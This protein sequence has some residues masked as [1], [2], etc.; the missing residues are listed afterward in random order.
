MF[1]GRS[2][3]DFCPGTKFEFDRLE[4]RPDL[5]NTG[6]MILASANAAGYVQCRCDK[7]GQEIQVSIESLFLL[8]LPAEKMTLPDEV[9][10]AALAGKAKAVKAWLKGSNVDVN[11]R[12]VNNI[13]LLMLAS[14]KF[15][16]VE[17]V[18]LLLKRSA[19]LDLRDRNGCTALMVATSGGCT[20]SM[21]L[22]LEAGADP[23]VQ[24]IHGRTAL[25]RAADR[26]E[27][28]CFW[29]T[30]I[31]AGA[32]TDICDIVCGT[33]LTRRA[34]VHDDSTDPALQLESTPPSPQEVPTRNVMP[35]PDLRADRR[36][37][38]PVTR[39]MAIFD[40]FVWDTSKDTR[41][42]RRN[43]K[44]LFDEASA[45]S[46]KGIEDDRLYF[47]VNSAN[48]L[49]VGIPGI[50]SDPFRALS[51]YLEA[52]RSPKLHK[53][54]G[55]VLNSVLSSVCNLVDRIP[56]YIP[57]I[58]D[59]FV[60]HTTAASNNCV[61][62]TACY[63]KAV[64]T[65]LRSAAA[66]KELFARAEC[67]GKGISNPILKQYVFQSS[68]DRR[69]GSKV[70]EDAAEMENRARVEEHLAA[71]PRTGA[72]T[73]FAVPGSSIGPASKASKATVFE[74]APG[75]QSRAEGDTCHRESI[76]MDDVRA[77]MAAYSPLKAHPY[78]MNKLSMIGA[79]YTISHFFDDMKACIG[80]HK[81]SKFWERLEQTCGN[82]MSRKPNMQVC[83]RCERVRYCSAA[84]QREHWPTHKVMCRVHVAIAK[85]NAVS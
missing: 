13:T 56:C 61:Q 49:V 16:G 50:E 57:A 19:S 73:S 52:L 78:L 80:E 41:A 67:L 8:E 29:Q 26:K 76:C 2:P 74:D 77:H 31:D 20:A 82:C 40:G 79:D 45:M 85:E 24:D 48:I 21:K 3:E 72:A 32:R 39:V 65:S 23:D 10:R 14:C 53:I 11:A 66:A 17:L 36:E 34:A 1:A 46:D 5:I 38:K 37:L 59:N 70:D 6:G 43:N 71:R 15:E 81:T 35:A 33:A 12:G 84:C 7:D 51:Q 58:E 54:P 47:A 44:R 9:V 30:L 69:Y 27:E 64:L 68:W 18:R 60:V 62:F 42:V 25:F 75:P 4:S 22:L 55:R 28:P 83:G 63:V